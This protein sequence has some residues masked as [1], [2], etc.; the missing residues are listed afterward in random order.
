VAKMVAN[1]FKNQ[2]HAQ[3]M[4]RCQMPMI[5]FVWKR[6]VGVI[7]LFIYLFNFWGKWGCE[8]FLFLFWVMGDCEAPKVVLFFL[9]TWVSHR[10][11]TLEANCGIKLHLK[12]IGWM[13]I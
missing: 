12:Y 10:E 2:N 13:K 7:Y 3:P 1:K 11:R 6:G 9:L 8:H 5:F 4:R